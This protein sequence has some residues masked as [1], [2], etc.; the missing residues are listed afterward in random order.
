MR[1]NKIPIPHAINI[2][3]G[4]K[5]IKQIALTYDAGE[6]TNDTIL[7]VLQNHNIKSTFFLTGQFVEKHPNLAQRLVKDGHEIGNHSY[8]HPDFSKLSREDVINEISMCEKA[9]KEITGENCRPIFRPP[10]GS[11]T[12]KTLKYI[13]EAGYRYNI[14]WS[15]DTLD[16]KNPPVNELTERILNNVRNGD[17]VLLHL[18]GLSTAS[19][20]DIVIPILKSKG[21]DLVTVSQ[22]LRLSDRNF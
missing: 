18:D 6:Y 9:I 5:Y 12:I 15:L 8:S 22:L 2:M 19:A 14:S 20:S 13:G 3:K 1:K 17:I 21:F 10:Y 11:F 7:N 16:W 4:K